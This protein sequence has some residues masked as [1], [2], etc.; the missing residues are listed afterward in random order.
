MVRGLDWSEVIRINR[1]MRMDALAAFDN[2]VEKLLEDSPIE[3]LPEQLVK[4]RFL[5]EEEFDKL[6]LED[7]MSVD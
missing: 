6:W 2:A 1:R 3:I 4:L 7:A 5:F